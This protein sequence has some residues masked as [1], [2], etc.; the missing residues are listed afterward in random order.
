MN[1]CEKMTFSMR[2]TDFIRTYR[3]L[4]YAI[5][6]HLFFLIANP[7]ILSINPYLLIISCFLVQGG[8]GYKF[9]DH[10]GDLFAVLPLKTDFYT[11]DWILRFITVYGFFVNSLIFSL[12]LPSIAECMLPGSQS[13]T[14]FYFS[15]L[16]FNVFV[17]VIFDYLRYVSLKK[18]F[19]QEAAL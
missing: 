11:P 13:L 16:M 10:F 19:F 15:L 9:Y 4:F 6:I 5:G 8:L 3:I 17:Y 12:C 7:V 18:P 1:K 2:V 14:V